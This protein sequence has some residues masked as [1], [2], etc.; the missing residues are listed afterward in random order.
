MLD[1]QPTLTKWWDCNIF[2]Q[3]VHRY[4][5]Y[6]CRLFLVCTLFVA[7]C[8]IIT[9]SWKTKKEWRL[10]YRKKCRERFVWM[11]PLFWL[12]ALLSMPPFVSF[13]VYSLQWL[14]WLMAPRKIHN[15]AMGDILWDDIMSERS[16][17]WKSLTFL[18]FNTTACCR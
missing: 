6:T 9:A 15:I 14:T 5:R 17:I 3:I 13:F 4:F 7:C 16:K 1:K 11:I 12:H 18:I 8:S 10:S 2:V